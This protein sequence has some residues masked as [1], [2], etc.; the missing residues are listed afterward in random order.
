MENV[1]QWKLTVQ[2]DMPY[3][4]FYLSTVGELDHLISL[5]QLEGNVDS[6]AL[7]SLFSLEFVSIRKN[8]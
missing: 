4:G 7:H 2:S 8:R 6:L 5:T 3:I 1:W